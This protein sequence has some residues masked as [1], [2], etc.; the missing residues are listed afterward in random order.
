MSQ[1]CKELNRIIVYLLLFFFSISAKASQDDFVC[2]SF[3][4]TSYIEI[5]KVNCE[6][7]A[8]ICLG[9]PLGDF[10]TY[11]LTD[12][13]QAYSGGV[14]ACDFDTSFAYTYFSLPGAGMSGP[15]MIDSWLVDGNVFS[16]QVA[17]MSDLV[18]SM[19]VWDPT[20]NWLLDGATSSIRGGLTIGKLWRYGCHADFEWYFNHNK[21]NN[22]TES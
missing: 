21:C 22:V 13:G 9:I 1:V 14:N 4:D 20:G 16:G 10:L 2:S 6:V 12:N 17:D 5:T 3:I 7:G 19:N 15:Y 11:S 8:Q 18:D